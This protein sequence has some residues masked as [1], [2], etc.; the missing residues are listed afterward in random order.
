MLYRARAKVHSGA[1]AGF[2]LIELLVVIVLIGILMAVAIPTFQNAQESGQASSA[3]ND[4][5][6]ALN[7]AQGEYTF[8]ADGTYPP[9]ATLVSNINESEDDITAVAYTTGATTGQLPVTGTPSLTGLEGEVSSNGT[10][11][12]PLIYNVPA[13]TTNGAVGLLVF[14]FDG[15]AVTAEDP[16]DG[17]TSLV[18]ARE[19]VSRD[20]TVWW[21]VAN[22]DQ[23]ITENSGDLGTF[24]GS[25]SDDAD[26]WRPNQ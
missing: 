25:N 24:Y 10:G 8:R 14:N 18:M 1:R 17:G 5:R 22:R 13:P 26:S 16:T 9:T 12:N 3:Q 19:D 6:V 15:A 4:L 11:S 7:V 21:I 23:T 2:T 20:N